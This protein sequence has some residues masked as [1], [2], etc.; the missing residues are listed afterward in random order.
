MSKTKPF[1]LQVRD[2]VRKPGYSRD[3]ELTAPFGEIVGEGMATVGASRDVEISGMLESVHEGILATGS[4]TTVA[5]A[6]CSRCL[7]PTTLD[8]QVDF[9]EL[10]AYDRSEDSEMFVVGDSID[11]EQIVR[12]AVVLALPF[13]PVCRPDCAGLDP[14]TGA[15]LVPGTARKPK[16]QIDPR[17]AALQEFQAQ[18]D[19]P[20]DSAGDA[21]KE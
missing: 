9:T 18:E 15:K 20:A 8:V 11:I 17:W 2:L 10:F 12:D 13:Q 7:D 21:T 16:D 6:E 14:E 4:A 19:V 3:L 5:D 1:V